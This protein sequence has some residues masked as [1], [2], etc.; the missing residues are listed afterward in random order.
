MNDLL[1]LGSFV[2]TII[3][4]NLKNMKIYEQIP[5]ATTGGLYQMIP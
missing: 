4:F 5:K 2:G 3:L 1:V